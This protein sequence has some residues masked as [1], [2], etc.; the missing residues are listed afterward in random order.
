[1]GTIVPPREGSEA[2]PLSAQLAGAPQRINLPLGSL[3]GAPQQIYFPF[4]R[5]CTAADLQYFPWGE[6]CRVRDGGVMRMYT[7]CG[8]ELSGA[9]R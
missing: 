3:T 4:A 9:R 8:L 1:M 5:G 2:W 6:G 7:R